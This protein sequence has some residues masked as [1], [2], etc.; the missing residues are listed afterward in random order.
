MR[1]SSTEIISFF[2]SRVYNNKNKY[3]ASDTSVEY[4]KLM[5][6]AINEE[7]NVILNKTYGY[8]KLFTKTRIDTAENAIVQY[9]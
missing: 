9:G 2:P 8:P 5:S 1:I 3:L 7:I 4:G 6:N